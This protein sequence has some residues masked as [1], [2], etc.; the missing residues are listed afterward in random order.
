MCLLLVERSEGILPKIS[1]TL[2]VITL[3]AQ[4]PGSIVEPSI[5][6]VLVDF[7]IQTVEVV[8]LE[9]KGLVHLA[10]FL[11]DSFGTKLMLFFHAIFL[12]DAL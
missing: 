10:Q 7:L 3:C 9:M 5:S 8:F 1:R 6:L 2:L 11:A 4:Q 12:L